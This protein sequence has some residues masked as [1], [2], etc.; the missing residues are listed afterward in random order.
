MDDIDHI[1]E[2]LRAAREKAELSVEDITFRTRI[3][4]SVVHA[5][6]A[7]DFG[8]FSSP[9]YAKSFLAQY[10]GLLGVDASL[11]LDALEPETLISGE[12]VLP[13]WEEASSPPV[14]R[15][16]QQDGP[17]PERQLPNGW[18]AAASIIAATALLLYMGMRTYEFFEARFDLDL[19][20]DTAPDAA[21]R[22]PNPP[23]PPARAQG[24]P[25][26]VAKPVEEEPPLS[27]SIEDEPP[28]PRAIIVR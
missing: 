12:V 2:R 27:L 6:E 17:P 19:A 13:L 22:K 11:W 10:S 9:T 16:S 4:K 5:L 15:Q 28:P 21:A 25:P 7:G 26:A 23:T 14:L 18:I 20:A 24:P 8:V 3:P 1:G